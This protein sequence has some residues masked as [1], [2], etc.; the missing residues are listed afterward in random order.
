MG[1]SAGVGSMSDREQNTRFPT[2]E[3][4]LSARRGVRQDLD[5]GAKLY[6]AGVEANATWRVAHGTWSWALAPSLGGI[7]TQDSGATV[8]AINLFAG[9]TGIATRHLTPRWTVSVGPTAGWGLY[10]PVTGG[11]AQ[12][13]WLGGFVQGEARLGARWRITPEIGAYRVFAGQVPVRGGAM[14]LGVAMS[15]DL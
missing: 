10:W 2:G 11:S 13:A 9:L 6:V 7:R 14:R 5:V 15:R 3:L 4:E 1:G 12:G 8:D